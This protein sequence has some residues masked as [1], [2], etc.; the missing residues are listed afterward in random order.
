MVDENN[1]FDR[2]TTININDVQHT[3]ADTNDDADVDVSRNTK[4]VLSILVEDAFAQFP[5]QLMV[6]GLISL[7]RIF[8]NVAISREI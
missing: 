1:A 8:V 6:T 5:R 3:A 7:V 2:L 4:H